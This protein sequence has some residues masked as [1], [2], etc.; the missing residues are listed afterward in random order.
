MLPS[1]WR[2]ALWK[3]LIW[4]MLGLFVGIPIG[5]Y[6]LSIAP[7]NVLRLLAAIAIFGLTLVVLKGASYDGV[8]TKK[9][10]GAIGV[11]SGFFSGL[12]AAASTVYITP[13]QGL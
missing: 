3:E 1:V 10:Y 8:M 4:I 6:I 12:A 9:V 5:V 7:E 13:G 11:V 2:D